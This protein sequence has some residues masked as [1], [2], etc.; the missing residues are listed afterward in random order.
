MSLL[1]KREFILISATALT[2]F[3]ILTGCGRQAENTPESSFTER[4]SGKYYPEKT[5]TSFYFGADLSYVN[6]MEDCGAIYYDHGGN[7][8][9]P[10]QLFSESGANLVRLRLW[11]SPLWTDYSTLTDVKKSIRRAKKNGMRVILDFHYSDDWAD[12]KKQ[13]IPAAWKNQL[14]NTESLGYLLYQY[15]FDTLE[16]LK[17]D[18]LLPDIVQIGNEINGPILREGEAYDSINWTR[19]SFLLNR[20]IQAVRDFK[21]KSGRNIEIMLHIAQPENALNWFAKAHQNKVTDYDWIGVSYYPIWSEY[22][23]DNLNKPLEELRSKY[24]KKLMIVETAYPFTLENAD[25]ADNILG[26]KALIEKYPATQ[27]GQLNYL[28]R[29]TEIIRKSGG[30]GLVYWEPAWVSTACKT[31]WGTGSHWDNA[32]LFDHENKPT[33]GLSFYYNSLNNQH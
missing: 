29:L 6:E 19:N 15:T 22:S 24:R 2:V 9:D 31:R 25:Q 4:G 18:R 23:L 1:L 7:R 8:T 33:L 3:H 26:K 13:E 28:L 14:N 20:G 12:P 10:Y 21:K 11:H 32:T 5:N 17:K 30:S 16:D 27:E